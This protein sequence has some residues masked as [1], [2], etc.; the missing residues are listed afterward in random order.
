M[1]KFQGSGFSFQF[2]ISKI[3]GSGFSIQ[4]FAWKE[5]NFPSGFVTN[6]ILNFAQECRLY[7]TFHEQQDFVYDFPSLSLATRASGDMSELVFQQEWQS[8]ECLKI[9]LTHPLR[10]KGL[11]SWDKFAISILLLF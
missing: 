3:Q 9:I 10:H 11:F 4:F 2:L 1:A 8:H 7:M 6:T 5:Y